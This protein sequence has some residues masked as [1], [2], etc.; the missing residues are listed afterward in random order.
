MVDRAK[1]D[2]NKGRTRVWDL[3]DLDL[4]FRVNYPKVWQL[5]GLGLGTIFS[6]R[7]HD[8]SRSI[9]TKRKVRCETLY[10]KALIL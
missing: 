7:A 9:A 4:S 5:A 1:H 10:P 3:G 6:W 2:C 8:V